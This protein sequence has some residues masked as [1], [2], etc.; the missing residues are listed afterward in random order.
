MTINKLLN[1]KLVCK[2]CNAKTKEKE[3][4]EDEHGKPTLTITY[5]CGR[6]VVV[7]SDGY[8]EEWE[9]CYKY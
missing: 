9:A 3:L 5:K 7:W 2:H 1:N 4:G 6:E 8:S